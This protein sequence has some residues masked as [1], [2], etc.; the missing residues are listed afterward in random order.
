MSTAWASACSRLSGLVHYQ[1]TLQRN[2]H[3]LGRVPRC[4]STVLTL[5]DRPVAISELVSPWTMCA[6]ISFSLGVVG[7]SVAL[8][9]PAAQAQSA[10][11]IAAAPTPFGQNRLTISPVVLLVRRNPLSTMCCNTPTSRA[12]CRSSSRP[13][14]RRDLSWKEALET[15]HN[16]AASSTKT[17]RARLVGLSLSEE[18]RHQWCR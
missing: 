13:S 11:S 9:G 17:G 7:S 12:W 1:A 2:T 10:A 5:S 4:H 3:Q 16:L 8:F 14:D 15:S 6:R 18:Q